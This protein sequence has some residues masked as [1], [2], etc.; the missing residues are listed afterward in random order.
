[1]AFFFIK[2]LIRFD[3]PLI[4]YTVISPSALPFSPYC[5]AITLPPYYFR[6]WLRFSLLY[7]YII[8]FHYCS[9]HITPLIRIAMPLI[10]IT[11]S[12]A[13]IEGHWLMPTFSAIRCSSLLFHIVDTQYWAIL[14]FNIW[15]A[16]ITS[17]ADVIDCH[18]AFLFLNTFWY[19]RLTLAR[20]LRRHFGWLMFH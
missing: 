2:M 12:L 16:A 8:S 13:A 1:L 10:A 7:Y 20:L 17:L 4:I 3:T 5:H 6:H 15:Y 14:F 18:Y 11:F 19:C 9:L